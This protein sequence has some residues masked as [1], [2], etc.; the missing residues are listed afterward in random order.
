MQT[1]NYNPTIN[2]KDFV[3]IEISIMAAKTIFF[4][5]SLNELMNNDFQASYYYYQLVMKQF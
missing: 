3:N 1:E 4:Q 2:V 5:I